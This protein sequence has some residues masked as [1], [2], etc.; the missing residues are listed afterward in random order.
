M[1]KSALELWKRNPHLRLI[2]ALLVS[3]A[4]PT[5]VALV[6][7]ENQHLRNAFV[8]VDAGG[9]GRRVRD[10]ECDESLPLRLERRDVG[11]DAAAGV[12]TLA[13]ADGEHVAGDAE[14]LHRARQSE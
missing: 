10:L 13:D 11:D 14:I 3:I 6:R 12:G 7:R 1:T 5:L 4:P 2:L 8:G 9:E